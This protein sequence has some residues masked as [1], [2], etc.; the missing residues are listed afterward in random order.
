MKDLRPRVT[1]RLAVLFA[2]ALVAGA[3]TG[4]SP[5]PSGAPFTHA[6]IRVKAVVPRSAFGAATP[7]DIGVLEDGSLIVQT[8]GYGLY[9]IVDGHVRVLWPSNARCGSAH[10]G[11]ALAKSF[12]DELLLKVSALAQ[13]RHEGLF[14]YRSNG[15]AAVRA[16][17]SLAFRLPLTF[18]SVAQDAHGVVWLMGGSS[19]QS[20]SAYS[21]RTRTLTPLE[22][23]K[24]VFSFFRSPNGHV[25]VS[26]FDGL[27]E[28]DSKPTIRARL[29][30]GPIQPENSPIQAVGRDGS[31]W[32]STPSQLIHV[33]RDGTL[34][35]MQLRVIK[36]AMQDSLLQ[37]PAMSLTMAPDGAVWITG[38][39]LIRVDDN[40]RIQVMTPPQ[41]EGRDDLKFGPDSSVW[42]LA[43]DA[44]TGQP[45]G[46][47]NFV[48]AATSR[49]ATPWPF[50]PLA[51]APSP[52][53]FVRCPTPAP[54]PPTPTPPLP[55]ENGAV[56]FVYTAV[57][58]EHGLW[59][60]WADRNGKLRPVRGAPFDGGNLALSLT[61][62]PAGRHLYVGSQYP[63]IFVYAIDARSGTLDEIPG[64]PFAVPGGETTVAIDRSGHY[65][66]AANLGLKNLTGY[67]IDSG[68]GGLRPLAWSPFAM[69]RF[70][71]GLAVNP[72][73]D[74]AYIVTGRDVETYDTS[75]GALK[76]LLPALA[77]GGGVNHT[78]LIDPRG[79]WAYLTTRSKGTITIYGV[80]SR[81]GVLTPSSAPPIKAGNEPYAMVTDP[82]GRF[83]Y[84]NS[85]PTRIAKAAIL[86]YRIDQ[87]N[88]TLLPLPTSPYKGAP[89]V[90]EMTITPDGAFLYAT[91]YRSNSV[92]GFAIDR[93][94]GALRRL[95]S[96][97]LR[98]G[99]EPTR[100]VSCRRVGDSCKTAPIL[101]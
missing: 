21:P 29:V 34:R 75:G 72:Q 53:P 101:P 26:N 4:P 10:F 57:G 35:E 77:R 19:N 46:I 11:F 16:D 86:G 81:T 49:D 99:D 44:R 56:N 52:T 27:Y 60:Y 45:Q 95:P 6:G 76:R 88:E 32:A 78:L 9:R 97:P 82:R 74:V 100:I 64:S 17:G 47:V 61:I 87:R 55:P 25:Y 40:D 41:H 85:D 30:H 24:D 42:V 20:L 79:Q 93:E 31:L 69:A 13:V 14:Y 43:R 7:V 70:P 23:P 36:P 65:A 71:F 54:P 39:S 51:S 92:S 89:G 50:R 98:T 38:E 90:T 59:G 62:D 84:V 91:D 3:A 8:E 96:S 5:S 1:I 67:A 73:R 83:L 28:L 18:D 22:S 63:G 66:L 37:W 12:D 2:A 48:P 80:D 33:H 68:T 15:S 94:T 58:T